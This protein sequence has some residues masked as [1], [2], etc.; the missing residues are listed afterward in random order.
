MGL[1]KLIFVFFGG[2]IGSVARYL[3]SK[4]SNEVLLTHFPLGTLISNIVSCLIMGSVISVFSDKLSTDTFLRYFVLIGFCG[5]FS[6]FSTFS[7]ET[8]DLMKNGFLIYGIA[9]V[10]VSISLCLFVLYILLK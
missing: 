5:G 4:I 9:N 10:F 6:T 2:G 1:T 7:N 3:V 8:L